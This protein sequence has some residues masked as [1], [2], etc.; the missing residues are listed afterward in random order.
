VQ[1]L[2]LQRLVSQH[3]MPFIRVAA[4]DAAKAAD[5]VQRV[6]TALPAAWFQGGESPGMRLY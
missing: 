1:D 3:L 4:S 2:A 5:R 6:V